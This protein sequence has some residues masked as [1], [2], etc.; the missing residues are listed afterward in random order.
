MSRVAGVLVP[1]RQTPVLGLAWSQVLR[2]LKGDDRDIL[3]RLG[4]SQWTVLASFHEHP[5]LPFAF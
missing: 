2:R 5:D 4:I 3:P 1:P